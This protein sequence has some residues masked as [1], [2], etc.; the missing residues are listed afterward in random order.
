[1]ALIS[2]CFLLLL[3][4]LIADAKHI[5]RIKQM[6]DHGYEGYLRHAFPFDE[7]APLKCRGT[8][9]DHRNIIRSR[10]DK[11]LRYGSGTKSSFR[12]QAGF[13]LTLVDSMT[14]L[15]V[16]GDSV[17]FFEAVDLYLDYVRSLKIDQDVSVF[18]VNIRV[19]AGLLSSH[20]FC[21]GVFR[22]ELFKPGYKNQL[23]AL[24]V[25][26]GNR[27]LP[28]FESPTGI[29][30]ASLN[31]ATGIVDKMGKLICPAAAGT[32]ILELGLL[33]VLSGD[34]RYYVKTIHPLIPYM[35]D[36]WRLRRQ[37]LL[38]GSG[39]LILDYSVMRSTSRLEN[40]P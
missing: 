20:L 36:R 32:F 30:Y 15:A 26:L 33:T 5:L 10:L 24:A 21:S 35:I 1:M 2:H 31:L 6:F 29:P 8:G 13:A 3:L 25:D 16:I 14:T 22:E 40:G 28:A 19:L 23:L 18:E 12:V 39:G 4:A 37:S 38:Y 34:I 11:E 17:R 9:L 7:L 27:L